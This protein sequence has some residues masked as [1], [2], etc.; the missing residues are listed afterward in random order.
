MR[1]PQERAL[2]L[3]ETAVAFENVSFA[4]KTDPQIAR[5]LLAE[6]GL[7]DA[8]LSDGFEAPWDGREALSALVRE[9]MEGAYELKVPLTVD[10]GWGSNWGQ[11]H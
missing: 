11:A 5:E 7:S 1:Q 8:D 10:V 3:A 4:G 6:A 9:V 2:A